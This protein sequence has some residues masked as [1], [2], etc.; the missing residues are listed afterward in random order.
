M[1]Y[2]TFVAD[3]EDVEF[4][5]SITAT[6]YTSPDSILVMVQD[7]GPANAGNTVHITHLPPG[8]YLVTARADGF[9]FPHNH[10]VTVPAALEGEPGYT[11]SDPIIVELPGQTSRR[12]VATD[13]VR[14]YGWVDMPSPNSAPGLARQSLGQPV[15]AGPSLNV[16]T[17]SRTVTFE[18]VQQRLDGGADSVV[19]RGR[20]RVAYDRHG[21][22]E[23]LL[24]PD[25]WYRAYL[26]TAGVRYIRTLE[27]GTDSAIEDLVDATLQTPF[28]EIR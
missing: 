20:T 27:A 8:D 7:F 24:A 25:S 19:S 28:T 17:V 1:P 22:F 2:L 16:T 6:V 5:P 3:I 4:V 14:V 26:P 11:Y 15:D 12:E 9:R 21:Y 13:T 10:L 18:L 23:A